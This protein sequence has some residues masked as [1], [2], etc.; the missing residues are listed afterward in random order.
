MLFSF[1]QQIKISN[2]LWSWQFEKA[3]FG[4]DDIMNDEKLSNKQNV[5]FWPIHQIDIDK[6]LTT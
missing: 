1:S 2:K 4:D 3:R 5:Q 6:N